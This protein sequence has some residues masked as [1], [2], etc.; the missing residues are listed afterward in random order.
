MGYFQIPMKT[1]DI[2]KTAFD[3]HLGRYEYTRMPQGLAYAPATFARLMTET[4]KDIQDT[5]KYFDD[6]LVHTPDELTRHFKSVI[7][8]LLTCRENKLFISKEK[9][10]MLK[11]KI[12]YLG[13]DLSSEG[14]SP[15]SAK[16]KAITEL[17][18]PEKGKEALAVLG[19]LGFHRRFIKN[20]A[21]KTVHLTKASSKENYNKRVPQEAIDQFNNLKNE[22]E[23]ENHIL[24][25]PI[26]QNQSIT[27]D[28]DT[29]EKNTDYPV[30]S[31]TNLFEGAYHLYCDASD[32]AL[33]GVLYQIQKG[34]L[35]PIWFHSRKFTDTQRRYNIGDR[36]MLAI[37]DSLHKFKHLLYAKKIAVY[38]DHKNIIFIIKKSDKMTLRQHN[39]IRFFDEFDIEMLVIPGDKNKIADYLSRKYDHCQWDQPFLDKIINDQ[40]QSAWLTEVTR[41]PNLRT[42]NINGV[43]YVLEEEGKKLIL[44]DQDTIR[45]IISEHHDTT[46]AGHHGLT[47]TLV[48]IRENYYFKD[49]YTKIKKYIETCDVCQANIRRNPT[50][51]LH[52]L[53][54]PLEVWRDIAIDF[55]A[56]PPSKYL[57]QG[58][59]LIVDN[60]LVVVCRLSKMVHIIPCTKNI[61]SEIAA[62][63]LLDHVFK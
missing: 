33:S 42:E 40:K 1:K 37:F 46:Y 10:E 43:W 29:I 58:V 9:T 6:I 62:Q 51:F 26:T 18:A 19:M 52:S 30:Q 11:N 55:F 44:T 59:E 47:V 4:F 2:E 7:R 56:L 38:T 3:C 20:F 54:I 8:V 49:M 5:T 61:T 22:F 15:I 39:Y 13:Y 63:L 31:T 48:A 23:I 34:I 53:D 57:S 41:N 28:K 14:I 27:Y 12:E 17:S 25:L 36:E 32:R 45:T 35:R 24:A 21:E 50:G 60:C 16:V